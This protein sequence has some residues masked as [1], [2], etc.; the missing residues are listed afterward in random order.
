MYV[1]RSGDRWQWL[2]IVSVDGPRY[3]VEVCGSGTKKLISFFVIF[4]HTNTRKC[5]R[6]C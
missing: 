2:R 6:K 4:S 1:A 3:D 5:L